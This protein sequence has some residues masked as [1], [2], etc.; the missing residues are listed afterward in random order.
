MG[1]VRLRESTGDGETHAPKISQ[2]LQLVP[3]HL[4]DEPTTHATMTDCS[5]GQADIWRLLA[6]ILGVTIVLAVAPAALGFAG[7]DV[8]EDS[9]EDDPRDEDGSLLVV[10]SVGTD[11]DDNR[12]S[13]GVVELLVTPAGGSVDIDTVTVTWNGTDG[14]ELT[15]VGVDAG[16]ASF[17][18]E[19]PRGERI[20]EPGE[21]AL[22]RVDLG[23]D[24][25]DDV[26]QFGERLEPGDTVTVTV[27]T[28]AGMETTETFTV[29]DPL[30]S[31]TAVTFD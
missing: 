18:V 22:L 31:G 20:V 17:G 3:A 6:V 1:R 21:Q 29:P 19:L 24:D 2:T 26:Q 7:I 4:T 25:I 14:P 5:R 16:D 30:P 13:L 28:D 23:T 9:S 10:S 15:P 27:R 12:T 11:I 8:R